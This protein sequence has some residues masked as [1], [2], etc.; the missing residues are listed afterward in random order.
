MKKKG[1]SCADIYMKRQ[2]LL[3]EWLKVNI[4]TYINMN[5]EFTISPPMTYVLCS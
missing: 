1:L 3:F 2:N 4:L 5:L